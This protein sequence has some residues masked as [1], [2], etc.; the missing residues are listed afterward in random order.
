MVVTELLT[1]HSVILEDED[2][3]T[4]R[5]DNTAYS[6]SALSNLWDVR[7][8]ESKLTNLGQYEEAKELKRIVIQYQ[9][10][11]KG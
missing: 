8:L 9:H 6:H 1:F 7:E 3:H 11:L 2:R 4:H 10:S 5:T